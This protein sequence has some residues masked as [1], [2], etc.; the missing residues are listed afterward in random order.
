MYHKTNEWISTLLRTNRIKGN[1]I[2]KYIN[3]KNFKIFKIFKFIKFI[4]Q[5]N[6]K[7]EIILKHF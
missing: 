2:Y 7:E 1:N 4:K 3:E 6:I 5:I